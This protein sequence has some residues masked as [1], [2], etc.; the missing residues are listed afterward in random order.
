MPATDIR[1]GTGSVGRL[2]RWN[3]PPAPVAGCD[4]C[5]SP[6][7][8]AHDHLLDIRS[9]RIQCAC[10]AC[11]ALVEKSSANG[12]ARGSLRY[13]PRRVHALPSFR[14]TEAQWSAMGIPISLAF[15]STRTEPAEIVAGY[16]GPAGTTESRIA[17]QMW[18]DLRLANPVLGSMQSDVEV[19]LVNRASP[20]HPRTEYFLTPIDECFRLTGLMRSHWKGFG[21]GDRVWSEI[22]EFFVQLRANAVGTA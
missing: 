18:D 2:R 12:T 15:F 21:G 4:I 5:A 11:A 10:T 1:P 16:P 19:L 13:V 6:I 8:Q 22:E 14:F 20:R 17:P 9:H 3:R 7:D